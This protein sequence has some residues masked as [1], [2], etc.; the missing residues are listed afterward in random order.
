M[1]FVTLVTGMAIST[2]TKL[3]CD[4]A[5]AGATADAVVGDTCRERLAIRAPV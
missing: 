2:W 5:A 3:I 1:C 4:S